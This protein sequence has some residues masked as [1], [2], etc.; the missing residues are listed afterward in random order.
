[1][2]TLILLLLTTG[3]VSAQTNF[4][5]IHKKSLWFDQKGAVRIDDSGI[6]FVPAG[7]DDESRTW[8]YEDIQ[9]L[10]RVSPTEFR[11]L[12]YEDVAWQL[13]Q[14]RR[15]R[16]VLTSG[17]FTDAVLEYVA[18]RMARPIT[19]RVVSRPVFPE[20]DAEQPAELELPAKYLTTLGGSQGTLYFSPERIVYV[21]DTEKKSR[22]WLVAR[23]VQSVWSA[24]PYRLEIHVYEDGRGAFRMTK[25]YKFAL[26]RPVDPEFYRRFK[27]KLYEVERRGDWKP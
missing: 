14:D 24:D 8:T 16:F 20:K 12:S 25:V 9:F 11:L 5:V 19:N 4:E 17:E 7:K 1:M 26:K 27:L 18:T 10:D 21:T 6:S 2:K 15:Y 22:E 3:L 13:G 23:D